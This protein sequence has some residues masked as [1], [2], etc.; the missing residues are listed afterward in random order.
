MQRTSRGYPGINSSKSEENPHISHL[1]GMSHM[2]DVV[3]PSH[4][5]TGDDGAVRIK[6]ENTAE[7]SEYQ[8]SFLYFRLWLFKLCFV[9]LLSYKLLISSRRYG[10]SVRC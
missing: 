5:V 9:I 2:T 10:K 1:M 3:P 4:E 6:A 8:P 7:K